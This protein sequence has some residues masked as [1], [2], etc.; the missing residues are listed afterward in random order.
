MSLKVPRVGFK[1]DGVVVEESSLIFDDGAGVAPA[2]PTPLLSRTRIVL[3]VVLEVVGFFCANTTTMTQ[4]KSQTI[5]AGNFIVCVMMEVGARFVEIVREKEDG[6]SMKFVNLATVGPVFSLVQVY[7][8]PK[9]NGHTLD[10]FKIGEKAS[11]TACFRCTCEPPQD[12]GRPFV[13][14]CVPPLRAA[15]QLGD[16]AHDTVRHESRQQFFAFRGRHG[17]GGAA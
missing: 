16:I 7:M 14:S 2:F 9:S 17:C 13:R 4:G 5:L 12:Q 6:K 10:I 15:V 3:P 1:E 11:R 8:H